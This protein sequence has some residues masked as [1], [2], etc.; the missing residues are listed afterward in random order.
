MS[1]PTPENENAA[2]TGLLGI[3]IMLLLSNAYLTLSRIFG[4]AK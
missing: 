3:S 4:D 2:F 1:S